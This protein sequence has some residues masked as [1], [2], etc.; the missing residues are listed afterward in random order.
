VTMNAITSR[1]G[2]IAS[3]MPARRPTF[4]PGPMARV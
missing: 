1:L 3:S 2:W 4:Q